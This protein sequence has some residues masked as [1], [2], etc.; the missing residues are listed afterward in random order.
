VHVLVVTVVHIPADARIMHRQARSLVEAGHRVTMAAPWSH[1]HVPAPSWLTP[2]DLPPADGRRRLSALWAATRLLRHVPAD[3]DLVLLH[4]PELLL[5]AA[6]ARPEVP[7]VWDV[8]EDLGASLSDK[9][10]LPGPV[11]RP[12]RT[13]VRVA[14]SW[15]ER[16]FHLL[17]AESAYAARFARVHPVVPNL[18]WTRPH[19]PGAV[20]PRAVYLGR[21]SLAR[22]ALDLVAVGRRLA[23]HGVKL[24]LVGP[25]DA[26]VRPA[27]EDAASEGVLRWHGFLPNPQALALL[28]GAIAGL[29]L[30]HDVPN[31][32]H[33]MP[34]KVL[35]YM[36]RGLPVVT[37]PLPLAARIVENHA[38]GVV[39][40]FGDAEAAAAAVLDLHRDPR[41]RNRL[42][43]AARQAA[44][45]EY[46]WNTAAAAFVE[47]LERWA[48]RN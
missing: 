12:V 43:A 29:S 23:P 33:S 27:L 19:E 37:A 32:R 44:T 45:T 14:E 5:A 15:A 24:V 9:P 34:T 17:L 22:G 7:V 35:E 28:D 16:R 38:C 39:V 30:L 47:Q 2:I 3:V 21:L 42:A 4:D 40:P 48:A 20:D 41:R 11:I 10:W 6:A 46:S 18:P 36:E 13:G 1:R 8:H 25:A 31:Y 26:D